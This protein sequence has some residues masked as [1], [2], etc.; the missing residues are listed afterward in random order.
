MVAEKVWRSALVLGI[1][2]AGCGLFTF[3]EPIQYRLVRLEGWSLVLLLVL[4]GGTVAAALMRNRPLLT[5]AGAGFVVA[6]AVQL[7]VWSGSNPLGGDGSTV[8]LFTGVGVGLLVLALT[9]LP[10]RRPDT[11]QEGIGHDR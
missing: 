7:A 3:V 4:A 8:S 1:V 2:A 10:D 11:V 5:V 6:A 9:P